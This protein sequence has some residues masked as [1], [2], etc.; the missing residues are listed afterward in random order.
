MDSRIRDHLAVVFLA[1]ALYG[2]TPFALARASDQNP[3][4]YAIVFMDAYGMA[5]SRY[6]NFLNPRTSQREKLGKSDDGR[7]LL[8]IDPSWESTSSKEPGS[9]LTALVTSDNPPVR[10]TGRTRR[11]EGGHEVHE[12]ELLLAE[13]QLARVCSYCG[14]M[15]GGSWS[16]TERFERYEGEGYDSLY[17]CARVRDLRP[18]SRAFPLTVFL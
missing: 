18:Y 2:T 12:V 10:L 9:T 15:E 4:Q 8:W 1:D 3:N 7:P 14:Q 5:V 17:W 13:D 6:L 11:A 16:T